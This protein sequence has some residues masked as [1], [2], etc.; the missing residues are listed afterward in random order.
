MIKHLLDS[1]LSPDFS[2]K[3]IPLHGG[4]LS[5]YIIHTEALH[6][7]LCIQCPKLLALSF[8][9]P[10]ACHHQSHLKWDPS[11]HLQKPC[12]AMHSMPL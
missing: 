10:V 1:Q 7:Q 9:D 4:M 12:P 5:E 3:S 6:C 8:V 11:P 2:W